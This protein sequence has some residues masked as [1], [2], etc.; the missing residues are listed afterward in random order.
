MG[1]E[2]SERVNKLAPSATLAVGR[3]AKEL[4]AKGIKVLNLSVGEPDLPPP[5]EAKDAVISAVNANLSRYTD[6]RGTIDLREAICRRTKEDL[7]LTYSPNQVVVSCGSKHSLYNLF[8]ALLD[9]GDEVLI[10]IPYWTSYPEMVRLAGGIPVFVPAKSGYRVTPEDL[11]PFITPKTKALILNS[12][13]NPSGAVYEKEEVS[14]IYDCLLK[15]KEVLVI[16]DDAYQHFLYDDKIFCSIATFPGM[17]ERTIIVGAASKTYA[18]TGW[19]IGWFLGP[20]ELADAVAKLQD[21][22]TSNPA[23]LSQEAARSALSGNQESVRKMREEFER[24]RR[25]LLERMAPVN[26]LTYCYPAGAFYFFFTHPTI[27][28]SLEFSGRL[29]E[30]AKVAL[31]PGIAFGMEGYLRLSYAVSEEVLSE[32]ISRIIKVL[33]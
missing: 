1:I 12:P 23:S 2:L 32:A 15:H 20:Q 10:P 8:Q 9:S 26:G 21:Q 30:E 22:S 6:S 3:K 27:G 5:Q 7:N 17:G 24:R 29:L 13:N 18:M 19:R 31:V 11:E 4:Q 16:S 33:V 25:L 28:N 14:A